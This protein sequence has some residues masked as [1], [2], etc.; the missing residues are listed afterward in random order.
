MYAAT[1]APTDEVPMHIIRRLSATLVLALVLATSVGAQ[2]TPTVVADLLRDVGEVKEKMVGLAE[3]MPED[4]YAWRPAEGVRSTVEVFKHLASDNYL[5]S[6]A[7][8][9]A[10]PDATGIR[11]DDYRT[12]QAFEARTMTKAEAVETLRASFDHVEEAIGATSEARLGETLQVFGGS[13]TVQRLWVMTVTHMH[14]H[15]GQAIAYARMNGVV[16]PWS[17]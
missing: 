5:L 11:G 10:A 16:P 13:M 6:A 1:L 17:R 4:V 14:E 9:H 15:L 8:G 12:A 2:H 7:E 3:A